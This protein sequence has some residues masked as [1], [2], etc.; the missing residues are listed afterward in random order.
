MESGIA[1]YADTRNEKATVEW[2]D[3]WNEF[4][5]FQLVDER[6]VLTNVN[7][8]NTRPTDPLIA[9]A[10]DLLWN[11]LGEVDPVFSVLPSPTGLVDLSQPNW[12]IEGEDTTFVKIG[13]YNNPDEI[14][15]KFTAE[16]SSVTKEGYFY[17]WSTHQADSGFNSYSTSTMSAGMA[18]ADF[19]RM[20]QVTLVC[21]RKT[22]E[23]RTRT[24]N[25]QT[26]TVTSY[27]YEDIDWPV[28]VAQTKAITEGSANT[29][30]WVPVAQHS[31]VLLG[32][33]AVY[34]Y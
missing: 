18:S 32:R 1:W 7:A 13:F 6:K 22:A 8:S 5:T 19:S 23:T 33:T 14:G 25:G 26:F 31:I 11:L 4:G 17:V 24:V 12:K 20:R 21:G 34:L 29:Y 9:Y 30:V 10:W 15:I 28:V 27:K 3:I 16:F 2:A